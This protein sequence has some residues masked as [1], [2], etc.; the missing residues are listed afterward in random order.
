MNDVD[1]NRVTFAGILCVENGLSEREAGSPRD[2]RVFDV[3]GQSH[4]WSFGLRLSL[5]T[6]H[7]LLL[8]GEE[9]SAG[10]GIR[11]GLAHASIER[12]RNSECDQGLDEKEMGLTR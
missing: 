5:G 7:G 8:A 6:S 9:G 11:F 10:L 2:E 3:A 1:A 4:C 12:S